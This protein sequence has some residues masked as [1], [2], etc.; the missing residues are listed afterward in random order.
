MKTI[1]RMNLVFLGVSLCLLLAIPVTG[2][3]SAVLNWNGMCYGFTDSQWECPFWEFAKNEMFWASFLFVPP[4]AVVIGT[5][6]V[7]HLVRLWISASEQ[8]HKNA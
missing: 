8:W 3:R 2:I 5:W 4:L 6:L 1:R 7:I